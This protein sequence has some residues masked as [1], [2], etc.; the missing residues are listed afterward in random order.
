MKKLVT[1][2]ALPL[3]LGAAC[4]GS[5]PAS[6]PSPVQAEFHTGRD[7]GPPLV[8]AGAVWVP[9]EADG[10][11][12]RIDPATN[13]LVATVRVG[14]PQQLQARACAPGSVHS[15]MYDTLLT[16]RC[17]LPSSVAGDARSVWAADNG[18]GG[19]VRI[20]P[21]TNRIVQ[22]IA[23]NTDV[24]SIALGYGSLWVTAYFNDPHEVLRVDPV[25][26]QVL[27][28]IS[29]LP[30]QGGTG[31]AAGEGAVWVACTYAQ[32]VVRIDPTTNR[33][34][35]V[36][37]VERYPLAVN[38][39]RGAVWVR[40]EE[41]TSISR[42]DPR[43]DRVTA[44]VRGLSAPIGRTGEDAMAL[45]PDGL[46]SGG[47]QLLLVDPVRNRVAARIDVSGAG[48]SEGFGSLWMNSIVGTVQRIDPRAAAPVSGGG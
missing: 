2:L 46:W 36:I 13:R 32:S 35:D 12:S 29:N 47:V 34:S 37:P 33:I 26:G 4:G 5:G 31:I 27:A 16:R 15:F 22:R 21:A 23:L 17:D 28:T 3:V 30:L 24:F 1:A 19:L 39:G 48:I 25:S 20:D 43:S 8:A 6:T 38:A 9:N 18:S 11:V 7:V 10:T 45:G 44:T 40:N 14:D 41:S 42:I